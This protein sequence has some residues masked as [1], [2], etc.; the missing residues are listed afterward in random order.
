MFSTLAAHTQDLLAD[1]RAS[2]LL[3]APTGAANPLEGARCTLVGRVKKLTGAKAE[4]ARVTYLACH[5][6]AALYAGFGDFALWRMD[7]SKVQYVGGFGI[8]K[9]GRAVDYLS[10][11]PNLCHAQDRLLATLNND[12]LE[13]LRAIVAQARGRSARG[14]TALALDGDGVSVVG[15]KGA[16]MRI[17][18][19]T[20][21]KDARA[22]RAR[23]QTLLK[24][25]QG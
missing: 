3:E 16:Q 8:A 10:P 6:G 21:A 22:W 9:W 24:H 2:V 20:P 15:A 12:K 18:F 17:N 13:D 14:W 5:P 23:F 19:A 11:A 1:D 7:I 4:S 25:T